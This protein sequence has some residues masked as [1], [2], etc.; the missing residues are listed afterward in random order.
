MTTN[1]RTVLGGVLLVAAVVSGWSAWN[2]RVKAVDDDAVANGSSY[3]LHDFEII[4]LADDGK[5]STTLRAP[6]LE[7]SR[8]D[9]TMEIAT[10]LFLMPDDAGNHWQ[11]RADTGWV[12]PDGDEVRLNGNVAGDSPQDGRTPPTTFRTNSL[13]VLPKQD[14]ARTADQVHM[15]RPGVTQTGVGMEVNTRTQEYALLS[16]VK[17]RY[18]PGK[19]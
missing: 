9:E 7:R 6:L 18:T 1:W 11:L 16:Q 4:T 2:N 5:E 3:V 13:V 17:T 10:P 15:T 8:D 19:R 14:L 12:S